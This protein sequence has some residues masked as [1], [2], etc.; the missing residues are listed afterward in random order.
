MDLYI[1]DEYFARDKLIEDTTSIIWTERYTKSGDVQIV[2]PA[3]SDI[4]SEIKEGTFISCTD[5]KEVMQIET[6]LVE[7]GKLK[8]TGI[9]LDKILNERIWRSNWFNGTENAIDYQVYTDPY[10]A[11]KTIVSVTLTSENLAGGQSHDQAAQELAGFSVPSETIVGSP[12][13]ITI[14]NGL[15]GDGFYQI[16]DRYQVGFSLYLDWADPATDTYHLSYKSYYGRDFT[17]DYDP[18]HVVRFSPALDSLTGVSKLESVVG[19]KNVIYAFAPDLADGTHVD[20]VIVYAPG[21]TAAV[22]NFDRREMQIIVNDAVIGDRYLTMAEI[23]QALGQAAYDA[24][25][26]NNYTKVVDGEIVPQNQYKYGV[27]YYLGD[28]IELDDSQG[29]YQRARV[30]EYIRTQDSTGERAYPT[31]SVIS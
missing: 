21:Y 15:A 5:T 19:F 7:A 28:I 10:L 4:A 25:A 2:A 23:V 16:A 24:L 8:A 3:T 22:R 31:V 29:N 9:T 18:A 1:L 6:V 13:L 30:T 14:P 11:L 17:R 27:D 26:N 20:P 12:E